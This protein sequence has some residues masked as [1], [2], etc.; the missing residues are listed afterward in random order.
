MLD[1]EQD[2][3]AGLSLRGGIEVRPVS[4]LALRVGAADNPSRLSAGAGIRTGGLR[5]DI[6]VERHESLG[7]TPAVGIELAF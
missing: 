2:L 7:I 1:A 5:A 3:D 4:M 6:A